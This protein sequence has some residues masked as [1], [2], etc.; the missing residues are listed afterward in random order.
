ML[1]LQLF[2][3]KIESV[4]I[5]LTPVFEDL[6]LKILFSLKISFE[7]F[8]SLKIF[9]EDF[10]SFKIFIEDYFFSLKIYSE[11]FFL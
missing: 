1:F 9:I 6:F 5:C 3:A 7:D 10:L 8:F 4:K 11:D 2:A